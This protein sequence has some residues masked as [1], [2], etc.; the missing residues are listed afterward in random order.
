MGSAAINI[1]LPLF[2]ILL[3]GF[4]AAR[5]GLFNASSSE[6]LSRFVFSF[7]LPALIFVSLSRVLVDDVFNWPFLGTLGGGMIATY[8]LAMA[9][10]RFLFPGS[11]AELG[12]HALAAMFAS[13]GYI[14]LPMVLAMFGDAGLV[15][16]IVG[17]V[18][19][20]LIFLPVAM[21]LAEIDKGEPG[22]RFTLGPFLNVARNP[23]TIA[24]AAGLSVSGLG[25]TLPA[26]IANFCDLLGGAFAPCA[27]FSAGLFMVNC[28]VKGDLREIAWISGIKLFLHPLLTW[29]LA[30][31]VFHLDSMLAAIAVI[32]A[33]L[34]SGV[35]V[36][37]LAQRYGVFVHRSNAVVAVTTAISVLTLS[38]LLYVLGV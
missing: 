35:P 34:P 1:V 5:A 27:L 22:K 33:A 7:S 20:V 11:L 29:W 32:Q 4:F 3:A 23:I 16:G 37:V 6:A 9:L 8:V 36:F 31:H 38:A 26:P 14:G 18:L 17:A 15:P 2:A 30:Y 13:T 10:A 19:T 24:T 25:F 28:Q 21:L 12:F